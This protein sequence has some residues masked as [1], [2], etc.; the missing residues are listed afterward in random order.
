MSVPSNPAARGGAPSVGMHPQ[1]QN[2]YYPIAAVDPTQQQLQQQ[3]MHPGYPA[4]AAANQPPGAGVSAITPPAQVPGQQMQPQQQQQNPYPPP[5]G[6]YNA[7]FNPYFYGQYFYN[8]PQAANYYGRGGQPMFQ[9][10]RP[11][12]VGDP[13]ASQPMGA[14]GMYPDVYSQNAMGAQQFADSV[15]GNAAMMHGAQQPQHHGGV[16][17]GAVGA[18]GSMGKVGKNAV[19]AGAPQNLPQHNVGVEHA[20]AVHPHAAYAAGAYG[21]PN[22][23]YGHSNRDGQAAG[24]WGSYGQVAGWPQQQQYVHPGSAGGSAAPG[25]PQHGGMQ[26]GRQ[27]GTLP[28]GSGSAGG[29]GG[30]GQYGG[31][32]YGNRGNASGGG[33]QGGGHQNW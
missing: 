17:T 12:G 3:Y 1:G 23:S 8:N 19:G 5:P 9:T 14:P 31:A 4:A 2:P 16:P 24:Q 26:Q 10:P 21:N 29:G 20:T 30:G 32:P 15:Y 22:A 25:F 13:Y 6:M 33:G 27:D 28:R 11:Y 18:A 7:S